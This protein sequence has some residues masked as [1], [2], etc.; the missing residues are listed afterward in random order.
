MTEDE[1][2]LRQKVEMIREKVEELK[3][4]ISLAE[5]DLEI[6]LEL[7]EKHTDRLR[8]SQLTGQRDIFGQRI[9]NV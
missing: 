3:C 7:E 5:T 6:M 8:L 4:L 1:V 2:G 9:P